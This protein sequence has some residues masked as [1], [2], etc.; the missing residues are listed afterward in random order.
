MA[1]TTVSISSD[2]ATGR[3]QRLTRLEVSLSLERRAAWLPWGTS[4]SSQGSTVR[5]GPALLMAA[6]SWADRCTQ[7][8]GAAWGEPEMFKSNDGICYQRWTAGAQLQLFLWRIPFSHP[9]SLKYK[10]NVEMLV[11]TET[12][13]NWPTLQNLFSPYFFPHETSLCA[14]CWTKR[15]Y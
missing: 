8:R 5:T 12:V 10:D 9:P 14:S 3:V 15:K 13:P 7:D 4:C 6:H 2:P 1:I 11:S